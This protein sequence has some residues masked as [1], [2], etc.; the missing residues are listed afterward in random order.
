MPHP[1]FPHAARRLAAVLCLICLSPAS[2]REWTST[3]GK[4]LEADFISATADEVRVKRTA[5]GREVTL[6]MARL[7][8]DDR[9]WVKAQ[10]VPSAPQN[11]RVDQTENSELTGPYAALVTGDW[12]LST[13]KNLPFALHAPKDLSTASLL[14]LVIALHGKSD[15][16]ENGKQI[17][18][19]MRSFAKPERQTKHPCVVL[20]PLCY[21]PHGGTGGGWSAKPGDEVVGLVK[22]LVKSL[23]IDKTRLYVTGHSMGGFGTCHLLAAEPRLFA[24]G[25]PM[26]GCSGDA[27][28]LRRIPLWVF[29][30]ADDDVVKVDGAQ[31]LAEAL[32]RAKTFKYT[33]YPDGGHGIA[34]RVFNDDAVHD[35]LFTQVRK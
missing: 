1:I 23:P 17:G 21:Q 9:A 27:G 32:E 2:A 10:N 35:W 15:N 31:R 3:D 7:S 19:W 12:A 11:V 20:A 25:I 33:E 13:Y 5:D 24:A 4:K 8:E 30:A 28:A 18:G 22:D 16:N 34:D 29:H 6:P 14:P 26:A